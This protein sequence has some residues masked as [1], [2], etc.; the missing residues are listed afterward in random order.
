MTGSTIVSVV[1]REIMSDRWHPGVQATVITENGA[2]GVAICT[3]GTSIG[4]H[5]IPFAYDGGEKWRGK[6]VMSAIN[7]INDKIAPILIGM[8]AAK[9]VQVDAAMLEIGKEVLGGNATGAVSAAVLKAGAASMGIPL[10]QHIG[11]ANSYILPVP[12]AGVYSGSDRYGDH[13]KKS[14]GKPTIEFTAYDFKTFSEASYALW[15]IVDRWREAL[16][17]KFGSGIG[18][19]LNNQMGPIGP[20]YVKSDEEIWDIMTELICKYGYENKIGIQ[21]DIASDTYFVK[22]TQKFEGLFDSTPRSIDELLAYLIELPKKWPFVVIED[23]LPEDDYEATGEFTKAVD[24]QV[25]GDD[26]FTTNPARVLEGLKFG[27][28]NTVLLKVNQIGTI[29]ESFAMVNLAYSN[30]MGVMPC[31]S[32]GEGID[33]C[34]YA[35]GLKT[36]SIRGCGVGTAGNRFIEIE[37]ELGSSAQFAGKHGLKGKRFRQS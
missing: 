31:S 27:A 8:D 19:M 10:Y 16:P 32:R 12:G 7:S 34:D 24:I 1:G 14:G 3:A 26:L 13:T 36:G 28:A 33:I 17:K 2:K 20:G 29:S 35:V 9:Q 21:M 6:G 11:G 25:V 4:T 15:D 18:V 30:G 22:E 23:P 5:E 37:R